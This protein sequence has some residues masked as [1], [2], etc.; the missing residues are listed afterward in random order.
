MKFLMIGLCSVVMPVFGSNASCAPVTSVAQMTSAFGCETT[1]SSFVS[2]SSTPV[3]T[4]EVVPVTPVDPYNFASSLLVTEPS[5]LTSEQPV[6]TSPEPTVPSISASLSLS[7][8]TMPYEYLENL[9]G[10]S[11]L[12][13]DPL[14]DPAAIGSP[15][16]GSILLMGAGLILIGFAAHSNRRKRLRS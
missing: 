7:S 13:L 8:L 2:A 10:Q 9:T 12:T 15:E 4:P 1:D 11:L 5:V 14:S 16:P 6:T 3:V